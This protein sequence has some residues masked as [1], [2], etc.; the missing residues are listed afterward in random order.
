MVSYPLK[1]K[2]CAEKAPAGL[3]GYF[4]CY[5]LP[6][7]LAQV[8]L[9]GELLNDSSPIHSHPVCRSLLK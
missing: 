1:P 9:L 4:R 8:G 7:A 3:G 5:C 2:K 6:E